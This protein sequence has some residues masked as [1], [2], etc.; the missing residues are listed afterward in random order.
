[1]NGGKYDLQVGDRTEV[2]ECHA[3]GLPRSMGTMQS[4]STFH[5]LF[6]KLFF[7]FFHLEF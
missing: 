6:A 7:F 3:Q 4:I 5:L 1:M 2:A